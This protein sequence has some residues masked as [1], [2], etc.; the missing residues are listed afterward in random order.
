MQL[1]IQV[2][3]S[4][5]DSHIDFIEK[6]PIIFYNGEKYKFIY[7]TNNRQNKMSVE[8]V[9]LNIKKELQ[10]KYQSIIYAKVKDNFIKIVIK[11]NPEGGGN[12]ISVFPVEPYRIKKA[13]DGSGLIDIAFYIELALELCTNFSI[14]ELIAENSI[15]V[16]FI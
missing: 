4:F 1:F 13:I 15:N 8:N 9:I 11:C 14:Y 10:L 12:L 7:F 2:R 16:N 3:V 6:S 5:F